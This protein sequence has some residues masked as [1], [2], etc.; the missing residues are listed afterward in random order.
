MQGLMY[1]VLR[2]AD[3]VFGSGAPP[4]KWATPTRRQVYAQLRPILWRRLLA[5]ISSYR[6]PKMLYLA[7]SGG[8]FRGRQRN[9]AR[10]WDYTHSRENKRTLHSLLRNAGGPL[11]APIKGL[12][13]VGGLAV[14]TRRRQALREELALIR[15]LSTLAAAE[16]MTACG[17]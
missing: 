9:P 7:C 5:P 1:L 8:L 16:A 2:F 13:Y 15:G 12:G 11:I 10:P 3:E 17:G 4:P 6:I 14:N